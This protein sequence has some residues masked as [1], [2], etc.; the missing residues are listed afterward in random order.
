MSRRCDAP[1]RALKGSVA[2]SDRSDGPRLPGPSGP[3]HGAAPRTGAIGNPF[4]S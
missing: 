4:G 3:R 2:C 1:P